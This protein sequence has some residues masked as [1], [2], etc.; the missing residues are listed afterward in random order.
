MTKICF[1]G[2]GIPPTSYAVTGKLYGILFYHVHLLPM[3]LAPQESLV[4][5]HEKATCAPGTEDCQVNV[6]T[7][8]L[9]TKPGTGPTGVGI[10]IFVYIF[11]CIVELFL[12]HIKSN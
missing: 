6:E 2:V 8:L 7:V 11:V 3:R 9:S 1:R 4:P 10:V 12:N 5:D